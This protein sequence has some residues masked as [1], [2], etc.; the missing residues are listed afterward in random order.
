MIKLALVG[1]GAV[2]EMFH[3][4]AILSHGGVRLV[5]AVDLN[6]HR[7]GC[8]AEKSGA[9]ALSTVA[10]AV[11]HI[12]AAIVAL[13]HHLHAR[14]SIELLEAGKDVLV[15]K[16]MAMTSAECDAIIA[17]SKR[18]H[19]S[20]TVGQMRRFCPAVAAAKVL[21]EQNV[22][23]RIKEFKILEGDIFGWPV[24]SDFFLKKETAG[25]G[26]LMDTG[27]H[28]FDMLLWLFGEFAQ[29]DYRDD[30]F[31]GVEADCEVR[32]KMAGG[33]DGYVELSRS[34][35]LPTELLIEGEKGRM[36]VAYKRNQLTLE[37]SGKK[38][39]TFTMATQSSEGTS[40]SIWYFMIVRQ[41][42]N[43]V[44]SLQGIAPALVSGEE[45]RKVVA[46]I[47]RCYRERQNLALP[48]VNPVSTAAQ[49][50][51]KL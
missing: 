47:E 27:A 7:A 22:I 35:N 14:V 25:G 10:E 16:P 38:L 30:S 40:L 11:P 17:A 6:K 13:P 5:A 37:V 33:A 36:V 24:V 23:G 34:R 18:G 20:L 8:I 29:L 19:A 49:F 1:C 44:Q 39:D 48:W 46:F 50:D 43:W 26:V 12:D 4:P 42:E 2:S 32:L 3:M 45:G 41:L 15:E 51:P 21:L 28:T 31:G 9:E